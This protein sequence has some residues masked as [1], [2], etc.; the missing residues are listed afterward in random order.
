MWQGI[1]AMMK[2]DGTRTNEKAFWEIFSRI[3][4]DEKIKND[5]SLFEQ[6]YK[7]RF[8]S[9][10]TECL[11]TEKSRK[12]IDYLKSKGIVVA[13]A[14]NPVFPAIATETRMGWVDLKM[15]D[16]SL[17][18]TYENIGY[19]KPNP[20]YYTDIAKRLGIDPCQCLMVGNDVV[21]DMSAEKAGMDV[22]LLTDC[23]INSKDLD[24]SKYA[25]GSFDE[26]LAYINSKI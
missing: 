1:E 16:F 6:F 14:T 15:D 18:T 7:E 22:F 20:A 23:L 5:F 21:D 2:N 8:S 4:G 9:V 26:L 24:Y 17:V 11:Y 3:Y 25:Q 13:L 19:C 12:L 10:K